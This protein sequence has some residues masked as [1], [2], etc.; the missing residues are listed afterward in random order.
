MTTENKP[1]KDILGTVN[2]S[3]FGVVIAVTDKGGA[4]DYAMQKAAQLAALSTFISITSGQSE[5]AL[6]SFS[7]PIQN[8][9]F[10]LVSTMAQE[11]CDLLPIVAI[12]SEKKGEWRAKQPLVDLKSKRINHA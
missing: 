4:L 9:V 8:N 5:D 10:W 7:K 2:L 3:P 6:S 1:K 12:E 11:V